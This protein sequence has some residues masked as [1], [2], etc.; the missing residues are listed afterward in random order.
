MTNSFLSENSF[1]PQA[2]PVDTFVRPSQVAPTTGFDQLVNALVTVNPSINNYF[3]FKIKEEIREEQAEGIKIAEQEALTGFKKV[4]NNVRKKDGEVLANQLIGGSIFADNAY[5]KHKAILLGTNTYEDLFGLYQGK[6]FEVEVPDGKGGVTTITKPI[7]HFD[8]TSPQFTSFLNDSSVLGENKLVGIKPEYQGSYYKA[9]AKAIEEIT[10]NHIEK[11]NTYKIERQKGFL[12]STLLSSWMEF[13][14]GNIDGALETTQGYIETTVNLG[15]SDAVTADNIWKV[16]ENQA[17]RIFQIHQS[18]GSNGYAAVEKYFEFISQIK[19]GPKELQKDGSFKQ[20]TIGDAKASD[21]LDFKVKLGDQSD[22]LLTRQLK[23][24]KAAED[25][26]IEGMTKKY[27]TDNTVLER[28]LELF[29][30]RREFLFQQIEI[31]AGNRDERLEDFN[32][33]VGTGYYLNNRQQM[34]S[35]LRAIKAEI[36]ETFTEEDQDNYNKSFEIARRSVSSNVGRYDTRTQRIFKQ[37]KSIL[38]NEGIDLNT[39]TDKTFIEPHVELMRRIEKRVIDEISNVDGL[40]E[41]DRETIFREI[42]KDYFDSLKQIKAGTYVP[43]NTGN[44]GNTTDAKGDGNTTDAKGD[45]NTTDAN[46]ETDIRKAGIQKIV[47][48]YGFSSEIATQ[49]YDYIQQNPDSDID[50]QQ[51][52][53]RN[54]N[55]NAVETNETDNKKGER[56]WLDLL[57]NERGKANKKNE[58][59]NLKKENIDVTRSTG[60]ENEPH[61]I[62]DVSTLESLL[63]NKIIT[64]ESDGRWVDQKGEFY[65]LKPGLLYPSLFTPDTG[66]PDDTAEIEVEQGD[67]LT[68]L[69]EQFSTTIK[70]IMDANNLTDADFLQ[71]GQK[72]MMPINTIGDALVSESD[73][74]NPSVLDEIDITKPFKYDSLNRLAQEVGFTPEQAR[75]MAAIALAESGGDAQ[76]D[77][78]K[79]GLDPKKEKE[80]S[81]GLWQL[82]VAEDYQA[83]RF[84]LFNIQKAQELYNPLTNARAAKIMFD[85][86]GYEAWGAYRNGSYKTFLPK[87]N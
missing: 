11:N 62:N 87:T 55:S 67:T 70:E 32:S 61:I 10:K 39:Y 35:D 79:S 12:E 65:K 60:K 22:K 45:G 57:L 44:T 77:T 74:K 5:Q 20:R 16:A 43:P 34:Y 23:K 51:L 21:M 36:G 18:N 2:S 86:Q 4:V 41:K 17:S 85:R 26:T 50:P 19:Y 68:T 1:Q 48:D 59:N 72:L 28:L 8:V 64:E 37:G 30:N 58:E 15:L 9:K 66:I 40:S 14:K 13:D 6:T 29:P 80:F 63:E 84:P 33:K 31:Y 3:D 46:T 75:I 52:Y 73:L 83:E 25:F 38:G 78:V 47:D 56:S 42:E 24:V 71:I 53:N 76:I 27:A 54:F 7:H 81:L 49:I 69:A 82:N